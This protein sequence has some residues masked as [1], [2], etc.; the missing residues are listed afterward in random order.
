MTGNIGTEFTFQAAIHGF[1]VNLEDPQ[2]EL[3]NIRQSWNGYTIQ[4]NRATRVF[5]FVLHTL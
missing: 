3:F 2:L 5:V 4:M 1:Y